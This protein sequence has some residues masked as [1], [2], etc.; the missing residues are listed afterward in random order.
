[1]T[2]NIPPFVLSCVPKKE[3]KKGTPE[4]ACP[5]GSRSCISKTGRDSAA[6]FRFWTYR[7]GSLLAGDQEEGRTS[8]PLAGAPHGRGWRTDQ[9][10]MLTRA[11]CPFP[12]GLRSSNSFYLALLCAR[13]RPGQAGNAPASRAAFFGSFLAEQERTKE[14]ICSQGNRGIFRC[15]RTG[16]YPTISG[17]KKPFSVLL[18]VPKE[19]PRKGTPEPAC[20]SGPRSCMPNI[21]R[22]P[23]ALLRC[24]AFVSAAC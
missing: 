21:G 17:V 14:G 22:G 7:I 19:E 20:P 24:W 9:R 5:A 6:L 11:S 3:P 18:C 13:S 1:M 23:A 8:T 4:P 16:S 12:A 15:S 2:T 10:N